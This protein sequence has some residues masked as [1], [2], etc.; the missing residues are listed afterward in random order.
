VQPSSRPWRAAPGRQRALPATGQLPPPGKLPANT[1]LILL[2][3]PSLDWRLQDAQGPP[4]L[5]LRISRLQAQQRLGS[6]QPPHS[7]CC[8]ATRR[9]SGNC[10]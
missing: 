9:W 5:V 2:D 3:L 8:G 7:A 4:T 10:A 6:A 1:R